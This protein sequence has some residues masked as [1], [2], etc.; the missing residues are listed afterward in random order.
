MRNIFMKAK[1][2][3]L[4]KSKEMQKTIDEAGGWGNM[5][6]KANQSPK[7]MFKQFMASIDEGKNNG[8]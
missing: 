1:E 2:E 8:K 6:K 7:S 4:F 5:V 3:A